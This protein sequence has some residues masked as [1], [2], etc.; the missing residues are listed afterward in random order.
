MLAFI[1]YPLYLIS[2]WYK[3]VLGNLLSFFVDFNRYV[4]ALL[5]FPLLVKTFFKPLKN[6]YRAGLVVFSIVFG[7]CIKSVLVLMG[8]LTI[9]VMLFVE[10][11][12]L[13]FLSVVPLILFLMI[14]S[15]QTILR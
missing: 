8:V 15:P 6:E 9:L 5:S 7:I 12:V 14:V 1:Y 13:F 4:A 10:V 2:F 3:D 11:L